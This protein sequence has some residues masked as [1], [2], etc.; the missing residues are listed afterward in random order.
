MITVVVKLPIRP[1]QRA[2][3]VTEVAPFLEGPNPAGC[4][5][6]E[7]FESIGEP[8]TFLLLELWESEQ[9]L[10]AWYQSE[11]FQALLASCQPMCAGP[12]LAGQ[13]NGS[14]QPAMVGA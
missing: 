11:T 13:F 8:C 14:I 1:D 4:I 6:V 10:D 2:K 9:A 7:C 5:S 3:F 12:P